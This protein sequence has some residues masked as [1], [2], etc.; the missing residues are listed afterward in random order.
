[1]VVEETMK[2]CSVLIALLATLWGAGASS[3]AELTRDYV[4][5]PTD[6][7]AIVVWD[8]PEFSVESVQVRPDGK[9]TH[10][11]LGDISAAGKTPSKL[12]SEIRLK[13]KS[14]LKQPIVQVL[15]LDFMTNQYFVV[16]AVTTPGV[17]KSPEPLT[18][19]QALAQAGGC[20]PSA[21]FQ[22][23]VV[24]SR[25]GTRTMVELEGE[26]SLQ[27]GPDKTLIRAGDTLVI[28]ERLPQRVAIQGAV[29][30][31]GIYEIP[32]TG[33][34]F[35]PGCFAD[36][37]SLKPMRSARFSRATNRRQRSTCLRSFTSEA[38]RPTRLYR[39][40]TVL[41]SSRLSL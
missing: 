19:G 27:A 40:A 18:I 2:R 29:K 14:E 5:R 23:A 3:A 6:T 36:V 17:Y 7:I 4:L 38:T 24:F 37:C 16:G 13:L 34:R 32:V 15:V 31:P 41:R 11:F 39:T 21:D 9:I 22:R 28:S 12:S 20:T 30:K 35:R 10:P 1:M 26:F 25:D 8:H 33:C